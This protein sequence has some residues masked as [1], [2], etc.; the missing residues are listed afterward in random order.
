MGGLSLAVDPVPDQL[1]QHHPVDLFLIE[2]VRGHHMAPFL[3]AVDL[4]GLGVDGIA[5]A[6]MLD[7]ADDAL[8]HLVLV[9]GGSGVSP[10]IRTSIQ[11]V[12]QQEVTQ[13]HR[14][15]AWH[16]AQRCRRTL[17]FDG[18]IFPPHRPGAKLYKMPAGAR[19]VDN[20]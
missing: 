20:F 10:F 14:L 5:G 16:P 18:G 1:A 9:L 19:S 11:A 13:L 4:L 6:I 3:E 15:V 2:V 8:L 7:V 12:F 17:C